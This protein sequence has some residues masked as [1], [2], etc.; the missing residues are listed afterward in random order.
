MKTLTTPEQAGHVAI[1]AN[2]LALVFVGA[3]EVKVVSSE[4]CGHIIENA[5]GYCGEFA[6]LF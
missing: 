2:A 4:Q 5:V 6:L 3:D 1:P